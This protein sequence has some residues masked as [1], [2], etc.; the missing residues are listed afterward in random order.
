MVI[1]FTDDADEDVVDGSNQQYG[2]DGGDDVELVPDGNGGYQTKGNFSHVTTTSTSTS[3]ST[4]EATTV[5]QVGGES[6]KDIKIMM[7]FKQPLTKRLKNYDIMAGG[8][9][10]MIPLNSGNEEKMVPYFDLKF[11]DVTN[12]P[13][14]TTIGGWL[15]SCPLTSCFHD[16]PYFS[17]HT[18]PSWHPPH[19][20][21]Q[22]YALVRVEL[23]FLCAPLAS[24]C[25]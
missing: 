24:V 25:P 9:L 13:F 10:K 12:D 18:R 14:V 17:S 22:M 21:R 19:T 3:T 6:N 4:A 2:N 11:N 7:G 20:V 5:E 1:T 8:L 15:N 16:P 23:A